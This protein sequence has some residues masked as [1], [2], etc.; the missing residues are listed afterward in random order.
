M[1]INSYR[2]FST[3]HM[4]QEAAQQLRQIILVIKYDSLADCSRSSQPFIW[5]HF[6]GSFDQETAGKHSIPSTRIKKWIRKMKWR[7]ND[8]SIFFLDSESYDT[9]EE[10][11]IKAIPK[12]TYHF[13][14]RRKIAANI[15]W[16]Y[17]A[18]IKLNVLFLISCTTSM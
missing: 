12:F 2:K 6:M 16:N 1:C 11:C 7:K 13:Q 8:E 10:I 18:Y 14:S 15:A 5:L 17:T 3:N 9:S 4:N